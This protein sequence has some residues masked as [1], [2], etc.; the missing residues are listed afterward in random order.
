MRRAPSEA[1]RCGQ[2]HAPCLRCSPLFTCPLAST[3]VQVQARECGLAHRMRLELPRF[4]WCICGLVIVL[5]DSTAPGLASWR[6]AASPLFVLPTARALRLSRTITS[7]YP[8]TEFR[9]RRAFQ[10]Q[11]KAPSATRWGLCHFAQNRVGLCSGQIRCDAYSAPITY[12]KRN[13]K[14]VFGNYRK[15]HRYNFPKGTIRFCVW[16]VAYGR[17]YAEEAKRP[18]S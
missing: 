8:A 4:L 17:R 15:L 11:A 2:C 13:G 3:R 10:L 14:L 12:G 18:N 6:S 9:H 7:T 5:R 1:S 16:S